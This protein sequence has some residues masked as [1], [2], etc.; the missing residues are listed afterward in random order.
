MSSLMERMDRITGELKAK[1]IL[2][3]RAEVRV[4]GTEEPTEQLFEESKEDEDEYMADSE[5]HTLRTKKLRKAMRKRKGKAQQVED[6]DEE[7]ENDDIGDLEDEVIY[8]REND[9]DTFEED[10]DVFEAAAVRPLYYT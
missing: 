4:R 9:I 5:T 2:L 10:D 6:E 3:E 1:D 8:D 7:I